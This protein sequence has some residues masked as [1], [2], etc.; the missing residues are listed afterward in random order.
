MLFNYDARIVAGYNAMN[1]S[2]HQGEPRIPTPIWQGAGLSRTSPVPTE[3]FN[4]NHN[5][6]DQEGLFGSM[7]TS[8]L[9]STPHRQ[10]HQLSKYND[11]TSL[12][13]GLGLQ[14]HIQHFISGEIDMT[15]FPTLT[16][17]DL[18]N[19]GVKTLGARRR[20]IMAIQDLASRKNL[21]L[22]Q[23]Q[24]QAQNEVFASPPKFSGSA[25]PGAERRSSGN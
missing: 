13:N 15:V 1:M 21:E 11:V 9:D 7:T 23:Q 10:R 24:Q 18:I 16:E 22:M 6:R 25:A 8:M 17:H 4:G 3:N 12:L 20:I 19:L 14:H 5:W 2:P